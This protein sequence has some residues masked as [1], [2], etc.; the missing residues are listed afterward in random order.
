MFEV[1]IS[2]WVSS[3]TAGLGQAHGLPVLVPPSIAHACPNALL[4]F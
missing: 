1:V 2:C 4:A 3:T